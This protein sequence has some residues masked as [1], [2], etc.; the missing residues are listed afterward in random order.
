ML[1]SVRWEST[2]HL[3]K[4]GKWWVPKVFVTGR[5]NIRGRDLKSQKKEGGADDS[6]ADGDEAD[7]DNGGN[8]CV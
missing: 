7:S 8:V 6:D 2:T 1:N 5:Y 4:E 3:V